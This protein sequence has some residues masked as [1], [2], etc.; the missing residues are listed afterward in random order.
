M[1]RL[2]Q[3]LARACVPD[4]VP[5]AAQR[6]QQGGFQMPPEIGEV[7][8]ALVPQLSA[9]TES[10]P[11]GAMD[12]LNPAGAGL[13]YSVFQPPLRAAPAH[14]VPEDIIFEICVAESEAS[15]RVHNAE[16]EYG[17]DR[18]CSLYCSL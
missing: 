12:E 9:L 14:S 16:Y 2:L 5:Q 6:Q 13:V 11:G 10:E 1:W 4:S 7:V 3:A 18:M 15:T 17:D 8:E